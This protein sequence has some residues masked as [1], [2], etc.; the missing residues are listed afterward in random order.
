VRHRRADVLLA[1]FEGLAL[2]P[3]LLRRI[4]LCRPRVAMWY[5]ALHRG[6]TLRDRLQDLTIGAL[7]A[8]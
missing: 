7:D 3:S 6:W 2:L 8:V 5:L 4:G 1:V